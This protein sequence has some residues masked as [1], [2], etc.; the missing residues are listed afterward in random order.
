M[1]CDC[2]HDKTT[3]KNYK[4]IPKI[5]TGKKVVHNPSKSPLSLATIVTTWAQCFMVYGVILLSNYP[6]NYRGNCIRKM[7]LNK[8]A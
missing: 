1:K 6:T 2:I 3:D 4:N 5:R 7:I 8:A